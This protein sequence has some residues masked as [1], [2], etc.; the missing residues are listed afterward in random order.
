MWWYN[1]QEICDSFDLN[2]AYAKDNVVNS[3]FE[4]RIES[5]IMNLPKVQIDGRILQD[6]QW[7]SIFYKSYG[8]SKSFSIDSMVWS[9]PS[10]R[11]TQEGVQQALV[12]V[13]K[14]NP[15]IQ[16][17]SLEE[18]QARKQYIDEN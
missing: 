14:E 15:W 2:N 17:L 18:A 1:Y 16:K 8:H 3:L 6:V 10:I 4:I 9:K 12:D 13:L 7:F 5:A 11:T